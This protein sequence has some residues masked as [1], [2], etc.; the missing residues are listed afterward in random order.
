MQS[1][2]ATL[3]ILLNVLT[4]RV[5]GFRKFARDF[6]FLVSQRDAGFIAIT[7]FSEIFARVP[8]RI[9]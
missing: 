3:I 4:Q 6:N 2:A 8:R 7:K 9:N 1:A 5:E